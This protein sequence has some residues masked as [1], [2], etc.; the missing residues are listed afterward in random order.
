MNQIALRALAAV[1]GGYA[2]ANL[3]PL[4]IAGLLPLGR[5][6]RTVL[7]LL[8]SFLVHAVAVLWCFAAR[9]VVRAWGGVSIPAAVA[10]VVLLM[11]GH[12]L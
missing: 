2:A 11:Q 7:A 10:A 4:A 1:P 12:R 5:A 3:V 8:L 6:D 9:S